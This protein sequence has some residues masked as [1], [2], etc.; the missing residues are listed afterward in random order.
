[1]ASAASTSSADLTQPEPQSYLTSKPTAI[2]QG[3]LNIDHPQLRDLLVCKHERGLVSYLRENQIIEQ[4]LL[5]PGAPTRTVAELSFTP[6][7]LTALALGPNDED[8]LYA[9]GGSWN[10]DLHLSYH[11]P[12]TTEGDGNTMLW[13]RDAK[14]HGTLNNSVL[15]TKGNTSAVEPRVGVT[16]NDRTF[17]MYDCAVR[18]NGV[19]PLE[20]Y[21]V[22]DQRVRPVLQCVGGLALDTCVNYAS[23]SPSGRTLLTVGDSPNLYIHDISGSSRLSFYPIAVLPL[24]LPTNTPP[25]YPPTRPSTFTASFATA[26]SSDS[27]HF[28][29]GSQ[30]GVAAIWDIRH[31]S[32]PMKVWQVDK[33]RAMG[34]GGMGAANGILSWDPSDWF[35]SRAPAWSLRNV[36]FVGG[37]RDDGKEYLVF[38][39]HTSFMHIVNAKTL[40]VEEIVRIPSKMADPS[41]PTPPMYTSETPESPLSYIQLGIP[42]SALS[43]GPANLAGWDDDDLDSED[44]YEVGGGRSMDVDADVFNSPTARG[45]WRGLITP[46]LSLG[47]NLPSTSTSNRAPR[48][49]GSSSSSQE[50][51]AGYRPT[52]SKRRNGYAFPYESAEMEYKRRDDMEEEDVE[53]L[54]QGLDVAGVCADPSG[55]WLYVGT[56]RGVVE[57]GLV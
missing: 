32:R 20:N 18:T 4:N 50:T 5:A 35:H 24:P 12:N 55:R 49:T 48:R 57:W 25:H 56:T 42:P 51:L 43:V 11:R 45:V 2:A 21:D 39:E 8:T 47:S 9:A 31:V 53:R 40:E 7:S 3:N 34:V 1:M 26:F 52:P 36:K 6:S 22:D 28:A 14:L 44:P 54:E 33:M 10:A 37:D 19:R 15:L 27:L 38:T 29:V 23:V 46:P 16:N 30:E 17:R 13:Q 41:P